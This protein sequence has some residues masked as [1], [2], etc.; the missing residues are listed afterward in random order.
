MDNNRRRLL[1]AGAA[2][3]AALTAPRIWAQPAPQ[4]QP[5]LRYPDPSIKILDPSFAR[6]RIGR[7]DLPERCANL[8]FRGLRRNRLLMTANTSVYS[9]YVNTQGVLGG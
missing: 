7:I 3:A 8:C 9:L 1:A 6:Y 2:T 5:S 4:W